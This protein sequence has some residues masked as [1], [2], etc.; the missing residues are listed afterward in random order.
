MNISTTS[1]QHIIEAIKNNQYTHSCLDL[2]DF[3]L[4]DLEVSEL[5]Q[6]LKSN[7]YITSLDLANNNIS[8][9]GELA[10]NKK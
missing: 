9:L 1:W 8:A 10:N 5:T 6:A 7:E 3:N 2:H 4:H